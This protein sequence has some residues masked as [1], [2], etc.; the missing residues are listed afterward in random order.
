MRQL[1]LA[2]PPLLALLGAPGAMAQDQAKPG[3]DMTPAEREVFQTEIHDYLLAHPEI[4]NEMV[5][6]LDE[7]QKAQASLSDKELVTANADAIFDDGYS[8]VTGNPEGSFTLVEFLDYQCG[9]CH[10]AMPE[11]TELLS[12]DGDIRM[13]VKDFPILGPGSDLAA[14]ATTATMIAQGPEAY[15]RLHD[16]LMS[17]K[18]AI[19]DESLDRAMKKAGLDPKA[20]RAAMADPEVDR[21]IA[22]NRAL[23]D[24]L[25]I[26]GTPTFVFE[27]DMVRG[28]VSLA[29]MR[30]IVGELRPVN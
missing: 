9:Y 28:Y 17:G 24:K 14:R 19:T 26:T 2:M 20:I 11:L 15:G 7:R 18:G 30:Q 3:L 27:S 21:R 1:L 16:V 25:S 6:V 4:L 22:A 13:I 8:W 29:D 12:S 23:A 5:K 10:K